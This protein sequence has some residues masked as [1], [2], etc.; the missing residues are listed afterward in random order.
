MGT[1]TVKQMQYLEFSK[2]CW[3]GNESILLHILWFSL[4][5]YWEFWKMCVR[6]IIKTQRH[7]FRT[8][9]D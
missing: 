5:W 1:D 3:W 9:C 4:G 6:M 2:V 8:F 7:V